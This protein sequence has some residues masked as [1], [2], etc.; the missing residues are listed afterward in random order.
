MNNSIADTDG[1]SDPNAYKIDEIPKS[2]NYAA[3]VPYCAQLITAARVN[4]TSNDTSVEVET[5]EENTTFQSEN[6]TG[7]KYAFGSRVKENDDFDNGLGIV[8]VGRTGSSQAKKRA[9]N[10]EETKEPKTKSSITKKKTL[11][12]K[13]PKGPKRITKAP[14]EETKTPEAA[15]EEEKTPF[16]SERKDR[17]PIEIEL[18]NQKAKL[19]KEFN[20]VEREEQKLEMLRQKRKELY[21][22]PFKHIKEVKPQPKKKRE[23]TDD[24]FDDEEDNQKFGVIEEDE[25]EDQYSRHMRTGSSIEDD[26]HEDDFN[27]R[28]PTGFVSQ[29]TREDIEDMYVKQTKSIADSNQKLNQDIMHIEEEPEDTNEDSHQDN[30]QDGYQEY[31]EVEYP[32]RGKFQDYVEKA[33]A[34]VP[35]ETVQFNQSE[36][37]TQEIYTRFDVEHVDQKEVIDDHTTFSINQVND[38]NE[39]DYNDSDYKVEEYYQEPASQKKS[40]PII[41]KISPKSDRENGNDSDN[42]EESLEEGTFEEYEFGQDELPSRSKVFKEPILSTSNHYQS[43][44][45]FLDENS[46]QK[47]KKLDFDSNPKLIKSPIKDND[48]EDINDSL[49]EQQNEHVLKGNSINNKQ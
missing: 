23:F 36:N 2:I 45:N 22:N 1:Y 49:D 31:E 6:R 44:F 18:I 12:A 14:K 24:M 33:L 35:S 21:K 43:K 4:E 48:Y 17:T 11:P 27:A 10:Y 29:G 41:D 9:T 13:I 46:P 34:D 40:Q 28:E 37:N 8:G 5:S 26:E 32:K 20:L 47:G 25:N 42:H 16:Q 15:E 38:Q 30:D 3:S 7:Y 19:E 39:Q